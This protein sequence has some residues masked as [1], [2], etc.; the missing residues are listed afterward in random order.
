[1]MFWLVI[2]QRLAHSCLSISRLK[3][4]PGKKSYFAYRESHLKIHEGYH[5]A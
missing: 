2:Y 3:K 1:M 4:I 5:T